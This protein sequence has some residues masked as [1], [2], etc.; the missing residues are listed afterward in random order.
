MLGIIVGIYAVA[1]FFIPD[2]PHDFLG[3]IPYWIIN[4]AMLGIGAA[5]MIIGTLRVLGILG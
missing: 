4:Q 1:V 5:C 3:L 2:P